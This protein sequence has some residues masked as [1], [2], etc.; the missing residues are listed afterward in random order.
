M[1]SED[2]DAVGPHVIVPTDETITVND[3]VAGFRGDVQRWGCKYCDASGT[4]PD[5]PGPNMAWRSDCEEFSV[6]ES[7]KEAIDDA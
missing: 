4:H 2:R 7:E 3:Q 1:P 6:L 5:D